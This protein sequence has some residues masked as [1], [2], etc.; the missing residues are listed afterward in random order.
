MVILCRSDGGTEDLWTFNGKL[1]ART[2]TTPGTPIV[3]GVGHETDVAIVDFVI[4]VYT[5]TPT[6]AAEPVSP[7]RARVLRNVGRDRDTLSIQFRRQL[8]RRTQAVDW[9]VRCLHNP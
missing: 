5:P 4:D 8:D 7:D 9:L 2:V 1:V 6:T 3:A